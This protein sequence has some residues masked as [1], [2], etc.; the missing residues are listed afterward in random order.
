[1]FPSLFFVFVNLAFDQP[2]LR[3]S[4]TITTVLNQDQVQ[5]RLK[6]KH[7]SLL[8]H[9]SGLA[10][11][12]LVIK[13]LFERALNKLSFANFRSFI[14]C[15]VQKS[16]SVNHCSSFWKHICPWAYCPLSFLTL[17][18]FGN[19]SLILVGFC[20]WQPLGSRTLNWTVDSLNCFGIH[21]VDTHWPNC[22]DHFKEWE[23]QF[24]NLPS[25][26]IDPSHIQSVL[27][28]ALLSDNNLCLCCGPLLI[29]TAAVIRMVYW[30]K[31]RHICGESLRLEVDQR[32]HS[33]VGV[34]QIRQLVIKIA[35]EVLSASCKLFGRGS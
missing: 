4:I 24:S 21:F 20:P 31:Q 16:S 8:D 5:P 1:M 2:R 7:T 30:S 22:K 18:P 28:F 9:I 3:S 6:S 10:Y 25:R 29:G 15:L 23:Q 27:F 17:Y 35:L 34:G 11:W 26:C 14:L 12:I 19:K 13:S 33:T 32:K